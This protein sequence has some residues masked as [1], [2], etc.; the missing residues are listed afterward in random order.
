L[1]R[2]TYGDL[3]QEHCRKAEAFR[4]EILFGAHRLR[5]PLAHL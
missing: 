4:R 3:D 5:R 2:R 1:T